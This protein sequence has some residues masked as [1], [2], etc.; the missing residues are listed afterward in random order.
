[1]SGRMDTDEKPFPYVLLTASKPTRT[2]TWPSRIPPRVM[3]FTVAEVPSASRHGAP[4]VQ[5]AVEPVKKLLASN[6]WES[7]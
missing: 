7:E 6:Q 5:S 4:S 3:C 2:N 1:M